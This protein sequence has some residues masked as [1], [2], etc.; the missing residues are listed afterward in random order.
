MLFCP[1]NLWIWKN[2]VS[3]ME[4]NK[5]IKLWKDINKVEVI[6][7]KYQINL[8]HC[9][10]CFLL[11]LAQFPKIKFAIFNHTSNFKRGA[12][13]YCQKFSHTYNCLEPNE[14]W[15]RAGWGEPP[16]VPRKWLYGFDRHLLWRNK[17][18]IWRMYLL[19]IISFNQSCMHRTAQEG[20]CCDK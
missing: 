2:G 12:N 11:L 1:L 7:E 20:T 3:E 18:L 9:R 6:S 15:R 10:V 13:C 14:T 17:R 5:S 16:F 19:V 4:N 8:F